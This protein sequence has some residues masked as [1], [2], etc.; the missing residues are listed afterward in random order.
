MWFKALHGGAVPKT[1]ENLK[2]AIAG[3]KLQRT[4]MYAEFA[5]VAK[6][7]GL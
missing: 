7:E 6:E 5:K 2:D 4:E 1:I 3:E